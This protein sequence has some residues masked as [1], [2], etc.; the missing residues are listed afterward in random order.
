MGVAV[1]ARV[2]GDFAMAFEV[3]VVD[4]KHHLH[5][6]ARGLLWLFVVFVES[7]SDVAV[8]AL[9][10]QGGGDEL[11]G[12]NELVGGDRLQDLDVFEGLLGGLRRRWDWRALR[13]GERGEERSSG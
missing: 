1:V 10:P 13:H 11:H 9:D 6:L 8:L 5:H 12:W 2:A 3:A 7:V 4:G